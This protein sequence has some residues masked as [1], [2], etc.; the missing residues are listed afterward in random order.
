M[1]TGFH[2]GNRSVIVSNKR[3]DS[4]INFAIQAG[5]ELASTPDERNCINILQQFYFQ[6]Y[7]GGDLR[8]EEEFPNTSQQNFMARVFHLLSLKISSN[9]IGNE[10]PPNDWRP[11]AS[12][13]AAEISSLFSAYSDA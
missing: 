9:S 3:F 7:L 13:E 8:I 1:S 6:A 5:A 12:K 11:S 4:L 10:E 2:K